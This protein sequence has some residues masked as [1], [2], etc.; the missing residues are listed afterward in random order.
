MGVNYKLDKWKLEEVQKLYVDK[1]LIL[2]AYQ[3]TVRWDT[4][5]KSKL[6]DTMRQGNPI[7]TFLVYFDEDLKQFQ[8]I[9]GLQRIST[10]IDYLNNPVKYIDNEIVDYSLVESLRRIKCQ[11]DR[12]V[13]DPVTLQFQINDDRKNIINLYKLSY[14]NST[15]NF[16]IDVMEYFNFEVKNKKQVIEIITGIEKQIKGRIE[17]KEIEIP[18]ISYVGS[19]R[20]LPKVFTDINSNTL[21]LTDYEIFAAQWSDIKVGVIDDSI[22][23]KLR[24]KYEKINND[25]ELGFEIDYDRDLNDKNIDLFEFCFGLSEIITDPD[26]KFTKMF[27]NRPNAAFELISLILS[28]QPNYID[29]LEYLVGSDNLKYKNSNSSFLKELMTS[30]IETLKD[31]QFIDSYTSINNTYYLYS[32]YQKFHLF[33]SIYRKKYIIEHTAQFSD[34][35]I[36]KSALFSNIFSK[37]KFSSKSNQVVIEL[38]SSKIEK[39]TGFAKEFKNF[40]QFSI[41]RLLSHTFSD[42]WNNNRQVNDLLKNIENNLDF[43]YQDIKEQEFIDT[44]ST[45]LMQQISNPDYYVMKFPRDVKLESAIIHNILLKTNQLYREKCDSYKLYEFDHIIPKSVLKELRLKTPIASLVNAWVLDKHSN[46]KKSGNNIDSLIGTPYVKLDK[47]FLNILGIS[48]E[49]FNIINIIKNLSVKDKKTYFEKFAHERAI[50]LPK[51]FND[52]R[53]SFISYIQKQL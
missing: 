35:S 36:F 29:I 17:L 19:K 21:V 30:I 14:D 31:L 33:M 48:E 9:D 24:N 34:K 46:G 10:I 13:F 27:L 16:P 4:T 51:L 11:I 3:R 37:T 25:T 44:V 18:I 20:D 42:Y 49:Q 53:K 38:I 26:Q 45:S 2:P 28:N 7:G 40:K 22:I 12:I 8:I 23:Q 39:Q 32:D 43:Y 6:I 50:S 52:Y 1:K 47:D 41:P 15:S 5:R